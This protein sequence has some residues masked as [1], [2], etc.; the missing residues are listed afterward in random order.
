MQNAVVNSSGMV[1]DDEENGGPNNVLTASELAEGDTGARTMITGAKALRR[2]PSKD[3][4]YAAALRK[5][6]TKDRHQT[7][8][9][10]GRGGPKKGVYSNFVVVVV[11]VASSIFIM[12]V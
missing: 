12:L 6:L 1:Q 5:A 2:S 4:A 10:K 7:R 8:S 3:S 9:G 11:L